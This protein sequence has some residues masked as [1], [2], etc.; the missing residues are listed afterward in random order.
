MIEPTVA[1]WKNVWLPKSETFIANQVQALNMWNATTIGF[2]NLPDALL[3]ADFAPYSNTRIGKTRRRILGV[4]GKQRAYAEHINSTDSRLIH[5]HFGSGGIYTLQLAKRLDLPHITTFHGA[6]THLFGHFMIGSERWYRNNL[7]I[8]F[9]RG[10]RFI[11]ASQYLA[12]RLI[13]SGAPSGKVEVVYTGTRLL[14]RISVSK[15]QGIAF[16]GRLISIKGVADLL[17]AMALIKDVKIRSTPISI[18]GEGPLLH[19]MRDL[20]KS[21]GLNCDFVGH[22]PNQEVPA[23]LARHQLFCAPSL[24]SSRGTREGF[25]MVFLEAAL[26]ELPI[27]AYAS[28]GVREAVAHGDSGLLAQEGNIEQLSKYIEHLLSNRSEADQMG[29]NGRNRVLTS[30]SLSQQTKLLE[31]IYSDETKAN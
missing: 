21:L 30:F 26:Q 19:E 10:D 22:L 1:I 5:A 27:V 24:P 18:A 29:R 2:H 20:A 9:Q 14:P 15:K 17:K 23:F 31:A 4:R 11:A 12:D 7:N 25:G 6:D 13:S 28:G 3:R 8:L 16:L